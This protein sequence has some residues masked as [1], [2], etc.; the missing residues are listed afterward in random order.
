M[1]SASKKLLY[2]CFAALAAATAVG[3]AIYAAAPDYAAERAAMVQ[4]L[5]KNG[6]RDER[7][8]AAM[9]KVPRHLFVAERDRPAAYADKEIAIGFGEVMLC[10]YHVALMTETLNPQPKAK[11]LEIGTGSGYQTAVLS[12]LAPNVCTVASRQELADGA[13]SRLRSLGYASAQYKVGDGAKGWPEKGTYDAILVSGA[14]QTIPQALLDQL[15]DGGCMV[16]AV[17]AGPE[18][19]LNRLRKSSGRLR[20]EAVA[21][22]RIPPMPV[23]R[24]QR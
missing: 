10:P 22:V 9:G 14:V 21:T 3:S 2:G 16:I 11:V 7:V 19:T 20:S 13:R 6:I 23:P 17:G 8:L 18:Q 15:A 24:R 4:R 12:E 5:R 1:T